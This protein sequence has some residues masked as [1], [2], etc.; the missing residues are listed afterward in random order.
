[1]LVSEAP[2][3]D[4]S[5]GTKDIQLQHSFKVAPNPF[6]NRTFLE[7]DNPQNQ[8]FSL[9]ITNMSGQIV[10]R[11]SNITG[12]RVLVEREDMPAGMFVANLIDEEGNFAITKLIVK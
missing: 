5:T 9:V 8:T 11:M 10:R 2:T 4:L 1:M 12:E 6:S 7:F 3:C